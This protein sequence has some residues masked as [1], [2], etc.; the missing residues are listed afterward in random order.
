MTREEPEVVS[1]M[2]RRRRVQDEGG[3]G[4]GEGEVEVA[5]E[6]ASARQALKVDGRYA[7]AEG[8]GTRPHSRQLVESAV[9]RRRLRQATVKEDT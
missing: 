6:V 9:A 4:S 7:E 3:V 2:I 8:R 5:L 1:T